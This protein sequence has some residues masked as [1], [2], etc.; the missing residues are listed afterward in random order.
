[1]N[2]SV[3]DCVCVCGKNN[4]SSLKVTTHAFDRITVPYLPQ[5]CISSE[6]SGQSI[7]PSHRVSLGTHLPM[8]HSNSL[9]LHAENTKEMLSF[10]SAAIPRMFKLFCRYIFHIH[11]IA[12][13][14]ADF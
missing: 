11:I 9:A 14:H 6:K 2:T 5:P 10:H 8:V 13:I 1:M 3:Y 12:I 7:N 4:H